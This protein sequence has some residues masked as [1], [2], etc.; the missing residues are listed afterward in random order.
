MKTLNIQVI[1]TEYATT[2]DRVLYPEI[3]PAIK[4]I[5]LIEGEMKNGRQ[6]RN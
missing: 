5:P 3:Y 1:Q 4:I 2:F 6:T